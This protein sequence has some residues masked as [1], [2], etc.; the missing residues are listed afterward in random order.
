MTPLP[1]NAAPANYPHQERV[2]FRARKTVAA[3]IAAYLYIDTVI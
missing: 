1:S 3:L 2:F